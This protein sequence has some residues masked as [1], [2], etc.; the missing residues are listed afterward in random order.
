MKKNTNFKNKNILVLGLGLSG[1]AAIDLLCKAGANVFYHDDKETKAE[2]GKPVNLSSKDELKNYN[3]ESLIKSPG[4]PLENWYVQT[5]LNLNIPI[6]TELE[7]AAHF[8]DSQLIAVTGTNGKTTVT[9]LI[10]EMLNSSTRGHA[11]KAG[12]IGIPFSKIVQE[13][14]SEDFIVC[15]ASSFQLEFTQEFHPHIA[16]INNIFPHH[17]EHHHTFEDYLSAKSKIFKNQTAEDYLVLNYKQVKLDTNLQPQSKIEYFGCGSNDQNLLQL[18]NDTI[19]Y[20]D[21]EICSTKDL[22]I[23]G[24]HNLENFL[25]AATVAKIL[26]VPNEVIRSVAT[27]FIGVEHRLEYVGEK[28]GCKFYNDSKATDEEATIVALESLN[29]PIILLAGGMDRGDLF[30]SLPK[31]LGKVKLVE[32]FGEN[33]EILQS[34][35]A[36]AKVKTELNETLA[37]AFAKGVKYAQTGDTILLSP[38][39]AS[40]DQFSDFQERGNK[41]K[42]LYQELKK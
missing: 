37:E 14:T 27:S 16:V 1:E 12:N 40:W 18:K 9:S 6:M 13:T 22:L 26:Q 4:I 42:E 31:S 17:L 25:A 30:K 23:P 41:F 32:L 29:K 20:R 24:E 19:Y 21:G 5:A 38:A 15:E 34:S 39:S 3:F 35:L 2:F 7:L 11:F 8:C 36:E 33:R 10:Y 28:L